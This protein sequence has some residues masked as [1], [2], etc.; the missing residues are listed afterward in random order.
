M[1]KDINYEDLIMKLNILWS[2]GIDQYKASH[3]IENY[4]TKYNPKGDVNPDTK[5]LCNIGTSIKKTSSIYAKYVNKVMKLQSKAQNNCVYIYLE[6]I[7]KIYCTYKKYLVNII[8]L[9]IPNIVSI[10]K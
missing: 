2:A 7:S 9:K 8:D 5:D 6:V 3:I 4:V 10:K 1:D